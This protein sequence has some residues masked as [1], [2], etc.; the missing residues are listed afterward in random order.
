[1]SAS[2]CAVFF[3]SGVAGLVFETLWFHQAGLALG[4]SIWASS[5]VLAAFMGGLATG[6]GLAAALAHRL[7]Q[8][9]AVYAGLEVSIGVAGVALVV[10]LP[11]LTPALAPL[12]G[13]LQDAP[14]TLNAVRTLTAFLLMLIP[15]AAMGAT[16]PLLT[17]TLFASDPRFG[18]V[19]GRLYGW[20]TLGAV[21]GAVLGDA[22]LIERLGIRGSALAAAG[23][24]GVA[25]VL[26][27]AIA[28]RHETRDATQAAATTPRGAP[29]TGRAR[30]TLVAAF[31]AGAS[32]LALEVVWFRFLLL[33]VA[34][35]SLAFALMLAVVLAG[36]GLG[37]LL[38]ARWLGHRPD[39]FR[40]APVVALLAGTTCVL[41]YAGFDAFPSSFGP[42]SALTAWETLELALP[43]MLPTSLL[44]GVLFT[45]LGEALHADIESPPRCSGLLALANTT[46][47]MTGSLLG[48][49]VL[50]PAIGIEAS[51]AGLAASY[52]L[53]A[54]LAVQSKPTRPL[55][56]FGLAAAGISLA[57]A[58]V[59]F[60]RGAMETRYVTRPTSRFP[61]WETVLVREA[62]TET[63][64]YL[65][66]DLFGEPYVWRL[67][68]NS[69][70]MSSTA[71][72]DQRYM[73]LFVNWPVALHPEVRSALL[74]SY[75]VGV[76]ARAL[77][78]TNGLE[79]I[80]VVD[81]SRDIL[82]TNE[83]VFAEVGRSPLDDPRVR[84]HVEDGRHFLQT[85]PRHFDL[86]TGEPPPPKLAGIVNLYTREYFELVR[87]RLS[88]GGLAS[89]WLPTKGLFEEDALAILRAFC[90]AFPNCSLWSGA[91]WDWIMLGSRNRLSPVS[92]ETLARQW[93]DPKVAE[94]LR[95]IGV[96]EPEQLAA[97]FLADADQLADLTRNTLPLEDNWPKRL[98]NEIPKP[99]P[100]FRAFMQSEAAEERFR[101]SLFAAELF[102]ED[103]QREAPERFAQQALLEAATF[104][105][106]DTFM[107]R[108]EVLH[109]VLTES[110]LE[111][112]PQWILGSD[113]G[114][115]RAARSAVDGGVEGV[116]VDFQLAVEALSKRRY[117]QAADLFE[118]ARKRPVSEAHRELIYYEI[119]ARCLAGQFDQAR[120]L[121][122]KAGIEL[123]KRESDRLF[124]DFLTARFP[125]TS[126]EAAVRGVP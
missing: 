126:G 67:L 124:L 103:L 27:I 122:D 97:L 11:F 22:L 51:V 94:R 41:T 85:T 104:R 114:M 89:Y 29:L 33:A 45:L 2:L 88:P 105:E 86:I 20:N 48:G 83:I 58:L 16:L 99:Q 19:L 121:A 71:F 91:G 52:G 117:P 107:G 56:K 15:S 57:A 81:T 21:L 98:R 93:N 120:E 113:A 112:L 87:E 62:L 34:G 78:E 118:R 66:R 36:I 55:A 23:L 76:T 102:D 73:S 26:A 123:G 17:W 63:L 77:V 61:H 100:F 54:A 40:H 38:G 28:R 68:T 13:S 42:R 96:E 74:I 53:T 69:H 116:G 65:R 90:E 111:T 7:R 84:V 125:W 106:I 31:A 59:W 82:E 6:N 95:D 70:S 119:Y 12:L 32:L 110:K 75:G 37:G 79:T 8:P 72:R 49:F 64:V 14:E 92:R 47:A 10:A 4:N 109:P 5:L 80:D 24:N 18:S 43:L 115:A 101:G 60:P 46:G 35:T 108:L 3:L 50:L 39:A 9:L 1:M 30:R 25:A 44:S